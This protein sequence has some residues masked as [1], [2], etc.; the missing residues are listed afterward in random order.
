[1]LDSDSFLTPAVVSPVS[2]NESGEFPSSKQARCSK[3][4]QLGLAATIARE[5]FWQ[6]KDGFLVR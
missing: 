2:E 6:R 1:V 5:R 3:V 4:R